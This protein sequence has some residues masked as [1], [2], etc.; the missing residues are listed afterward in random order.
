MLLVVN[1]LADKVGD[2]GY[3]LFRGGNGYEQKQRRTPCRSDP[4]FQGG[5]NSLH[6]GKLPF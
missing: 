3:G 2:G 4:G 5:Q 6:G 1:K